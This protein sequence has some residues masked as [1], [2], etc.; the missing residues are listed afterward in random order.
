MGKHRAQAQFDRAKWRLALLL[1]MWLLQLGL[2]L[3]MVGLFGWRLGDTLK[4]YEDRD[5]KG[6]LPVIEVVWEATNVGLAFVA[7]VCTFYEIAKYSAESLTPWTMLF[8]HVMKLTCASAILALDVVV[9]VQRHDRHYSLIGLG[10][11]GGFILTALILVVYTIRIYRRLSVY[12]DY[13]H[14]VN[15]K[16]FGFA[17]E[18][19]DISYQS[20]LGGVRPSLEQRF[21]SASSRMSLSST[22]NEPIE[23][24]KMERTPSVYSHKRDTQF[25]AYVARRNSVGTVDRAVSGEFGWSG[26]PVDLQE[27]LARRES[28]GTGNVVT[29]PRGA[30]MPRA[31]S[32]AS[33]RGLVAV[34]EEED[35]PA[36][37]HDKAAEHK[38]AREALLGDTPRESV[39]GPMVHQEVDL[40]DPRWRQS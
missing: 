21:S 34:P 31:P 32:W 19:R 16:P 6:E 20:N 28:I 22:K 12:D 3:A 17:D 1:P 9:Y 27:E 26:S 15:V 18:E 14:P 36:D 35:E 33:D 10:L 40:A 29:R 5:K 8:T 25:D 2:N 4:T 7:S 11:D 30:S 13:A 23:L 24:N 37:K 39:D 38:K